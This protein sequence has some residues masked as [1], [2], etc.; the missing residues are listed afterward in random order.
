MEPPRE[1][2]RSCGPA[3]ATARRIHDLR[4]ASGSRGLPMCDACL[5]RWTIA[6]GFT[7]ESRRLLEVMAQACGG[8]IWWDGSAC[9]VLRR[10]AQQLIARPWP[11][12]EAPAP[13]SA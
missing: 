5:R 4:D 6:W 8:S 3:S 7:D 11:G 10:D 2:C 1:F 13:E 9:Y 12:F